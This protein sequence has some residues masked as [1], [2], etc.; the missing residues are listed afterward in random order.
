L[1]YKGIYVPES[2]MEQDVDPTRRFN[3][4]KDTYCD[5]DEILPRGLL[6][7]WSA[8]THER[9]QEILDNADNLLSNEILMEAEGINE[10]CIP[11]RYIEGAAIYVNIQDGT[12]CQRRLIYIVMA[13]IKEWIK[14]QTRSTTK[15][16]YYV[17]LWCCKRSITLMKLFVHSV[18]ISQID[19]DW[20]C[21]DWEEFCS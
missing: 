1:Q 10:L 3:N 2:T 5:P 4:N 15:R 8:R 13:K 14:H 11:K 7:D 20:R 18:N 19:S 16:K 9:S 6:I 12:N 17:V 21:R